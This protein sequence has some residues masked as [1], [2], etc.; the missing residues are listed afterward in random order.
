M[1]TQTTD[2]AAEPKRRPK[3]QLPPLAY[4]IDDAAQVVGLG[5][6]SIYELIAAGKLKSVIVHGRR[7]IPAGALRAL[8]SGR[9]RS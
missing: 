6:S 4:R 9:S 2:V 1:E 7:L 8:V 3:Q 5:R